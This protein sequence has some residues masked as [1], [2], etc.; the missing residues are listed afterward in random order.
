[1][2]DQQLITDPDWGAPPKVS[3]PPPPTAATLAETRMPAGVPARGRGTQFDPEKAQRG[4]ELAT[5][6]LA[7]PTGVDA[8]DSMTSPL[9]II[10]TALG[11]GAVAKAGAAGGAAAAAKNALSQ[12]TPLVKYEATKTVLTHLGIPGPLAGVAAAVV[13]GYKKGGAVAEAE[14]AAPTAESFGVRTG[15][16]APKG[17]PSGPLRE[18]YPNGL[19]IEPATS[20]AGSAPAAPPPAA[21]PAAAPSTAAP[22]PAAAAVP[23]PILKAAAGLRQAGY[24]KDEIE[25]AI[26]WLKQGVSSADVVKRLTATRA[27]TASGPFANLPTSID[28]AK[29]VTTRNQTGRWPE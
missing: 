24:S 6:P 29:A 11:I 4:V 1:M 16:P 28:V 17:M 19:P 15:T 21:P 2:S 27:M 13:S 23:E 3:E 9:G 7:R 12:A 10:S 5:T 25:Q 8:I 22:P 18:R 20:P 26:Q 14:A